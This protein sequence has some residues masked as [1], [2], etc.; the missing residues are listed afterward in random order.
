MNCTAIGGAA[1]GGVGDGGQA[2]TAVVAGAAIGGLLLLLLLLLLL[3][4]LF[5]CISRRRK[6]RKAAA[7]EPAGT[8]LPP[9]A[10]TAWVASPAVT[11]AAL[12]EGL[13]NDAADRESREKP[14][15]TAEEIARAERARRALEAAAAAEA[16]AEAERAAFL[17][18]EAAAAA[19]RAEARRIAAA[20]Q[21]RAEA[22]A[23]L[24]EAEARVA[25]QRRVEAR[26]AQLRRARQ[27][28]R[29]LT[30]TPPVEE[31]G[32][33]P[34]SSQTYAVAP[35]PPAEACDNAPSLAPVAA[36]E[37]AAEESDVAA[38]LSASD[39]EG[40]ARGANSADYSE[41]AAAAPTTGGAAAP[42]ATDAAGEA[43]GGAE[44]TL[45]GGP[46]VRQAQALIWRP[47]GV[48][49]PAA[50]REMPGW[51]SKVQRLRAR[52]RNSQRA[53]RPAPA[54]EAG[55]GAWV[56][57]VRVDLAAATRYLGGAPAPSARGED[58]SHR[59]SSDDLLGG[60]GDSEDVER[61][62]SGG[63][64]RRSGDYTARGRGHLPL[65][66]L[67]TASPQSP[68][69]SSGR[70]QRLAGE[71]TAAA[72][73]LP[74]RVVGP[75]DEGL[76]QFPPAPVASPGANAPAAFPGGSPARRGATPRS[77][78]ARSGS[79]LSVLGGSGGPFPADTGPASLPARPLNPVSPT[80]SVP[81][82]PPPPAQSQ[83]LVLVRCGTL[84]SYAL[85]RAASHAASADPMTQV[86]SPGVVPAGAAAQVP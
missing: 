83:Q 41:Q 47:T 65:S 26:A 31:Q 10:P 61:P 37:E 17:E 23:A 73:A 2:S 32:Q 45:R 21:A 8:E 11:A 35:A 4:L 55:G 22:A 39:A 66:S 70:D 6:A 29:L 53:A 18:A 46:P 25:T 71:A 67:A 7:A 36:V 59:S 51:I 80:R 19:A 77:V 62:D 16:K 54:A 43:G 3:V 40:S 63:S 50:G 85:D 64:A 33:R 49:A 52:L 38:G 34:S 48:A 86:S 12:E 9:G 79:A 13:A 60:G 28:P 81:G 30:L 72:P 20:Q 58:L 68:V 78:L 69:R 5:F 44:Y 14:L 56:N 27:R 57:G 74:G 84:S 82:K 1:A 42:P 75:S 15:A 76:L 24:A